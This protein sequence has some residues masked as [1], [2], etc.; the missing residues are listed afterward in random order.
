MRTIS[1]KELKEILE[2]H[3][4]WLND[5]D[6]GGEKADLRETDLSGADLRGKD[7]RQA[8]LRET[9]LSGADLQGT[10]LQYASL[11]RADLSSTDLRYASLRYASLRYADLRGSN[12]NNSA[13]RCANLYCAD[14]RG[15]DLRGADL[16]DAKLYGTDLRC[17][18]RPWLV[19]AEHIGSRRSETL[20]FADYDNVRCG[21]WNNYI[22]GTLTEFKERIDEVYL[23]GSKSEACRRYRIEYLSAIRMFE[24][25]REAYLSSVLKEKNNEDNITERIE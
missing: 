12:L 14:L 24:S 18:Y 1:Q 21:C 9:D 2:K 25:M 10:D 17:V 22:G 5:D 16:R 13:L 3:K 11:L 8:D 4:K 19:I 6:E 7:L 20:Y 23:A 15:A